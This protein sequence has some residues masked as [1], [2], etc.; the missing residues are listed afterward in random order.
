MIAG[1]DGSDHAGGGPR[2]G[3]PHDA[4][5]VLVLAVLVLGYLPE[6]LVELAREGAVAGVT[7][8]GAAVDGL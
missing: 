8:R 2:S 3:A 5:P 1:P 6:F 7:V 4:L